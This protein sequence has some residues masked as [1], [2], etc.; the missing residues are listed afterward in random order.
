MSAPEKAVIE[1]EAEAEAD[2]DTGA[3][4]IYSLPSI[5]GFILTLTLLIYS[6]FKPHDRPSRSRGRKDANYGRH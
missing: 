5:V 6:Y 2:A 4:G 1:G 3:E